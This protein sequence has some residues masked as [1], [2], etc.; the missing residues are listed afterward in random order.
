VLQH[1]STELQRSTF[2]SL[3]AKSASFAC[4]D[5]RSEEPI[6]GT[7]GGDVGALGHCTGSQAGKGLTRVSGLLGKS[8]ERRS[9]E[10]RA[11]PTGPSPPKPSRMRHAKQQAQ[12]GCAAGLGS[13]PSAASL[14]RAGN[15]H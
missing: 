14:E 8:K 11:L 13:P 4:V 10:C 2:Q 5:S 15:P 3:S 1:F 12:D 6:L 9:R 7:P